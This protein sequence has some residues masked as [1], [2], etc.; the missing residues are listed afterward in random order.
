MQ[1]INANHLCPRPG[2]QAGA[3]IFTAHAVSLLFLTLI[4]QKISG[5]T[6]AMVDWAESMRSGL[7]NALTASP[8]KA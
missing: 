1:A 8:G 4:I 5:T 7:A 3:N 6:K 2:T